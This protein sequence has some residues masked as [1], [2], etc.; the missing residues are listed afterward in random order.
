MRR[1]GSLW[2]RLISWENLVLAA[3]KAQRSKRDRASVQRFNFDQEAELLRLQAELAEATYQP[4]TFRTHWISHPKPRM[5][6]AAPYRDRV[7]HHA[8]MNI[9][10]PILDRHF[11]PDS[12]ACRRGKG[13]HAA[14]NRLQTLMRR[15][16]YVLQCDIRAFFPSID[17]EILKGIFRRRIKD[18]RVLRLMD[19]IVDRSNPQPSSVCWFRGDDL[20]TPLGRRVG[21]PIGNLTSQW[22]ANWYL[23]GLD[24]FVTSGLGIGGYVRYCD[25]FLLLADD[26]RV[27]REVFGRIEGYLEGLRLKFHR[28]KCFV[29]PV[30]GGITFVG[31]R[32][33]PSH[34][35]LK[36]ANIRGFR[37]RVAWMREAYKLGL[38]DWSDVQVRLDSWM[39]HAGHVNSGYLIR[40]LSRDWRFVRGRVDHESCYSRRFL[41]QQCEQLSRDEPQQQHAIESQQ[42]QRISSRP[43]LSRSQSSARNP[44]LHGDRERGGESPDPVPEPRPFWWG[45]GRMNAARPA[46]AGRHDRTSRPVSLNE[47]PPH[48]RA[49]CG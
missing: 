22:F 14:A 27:L 35:R 36:K 28:H 7:V 45:P 24:H 17:H 20:F 25:D 48:W 6:S 42:Q 47:T 16:R 26:R 2:D 15:Y 18:G 31:Y 30:R 38:L 1:Y 37:R 44:G 12:Y 49:Q 13:T 19:L 21:L 3:C 29:R 34:R 23:D 43:A 41:E 32:L 46:G 11:H 5:I 10:E 39:G 33:W 40:R 9:L 4:G 8:L